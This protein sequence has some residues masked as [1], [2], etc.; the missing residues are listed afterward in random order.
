MW[1]EWVTQPANLELSSGAVH[2]W[3]AWLKQPH[4]V[5]GRLAG[6][7]SQDEQ[8]RAGRFRFAQDRMSFVVARGILRN[9]LAGYLQTDPGSIRFAYSPNGKPALSTAIE[10]IPL[11][12]NISHSHGLAIYAVTRSCEVGIDAEYIRPLDDLNAIIEVIFSPA[13][14][15]LLHDLPAAEQLRAFFTGWVRKEAYVKAIG[16]GLARSIDQ[17]DVLFFTEHPATVWQPLVGPQPLLG[18]TLIDLFPIPD[19]SAALV[20]DGDG[21]ELSQWHWAE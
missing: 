13:E 6:T 3:R 19:Y 4:S 14:R 10:K 16:E 8:L 17:I 7:L 5:A 12:F 18:R 15:K 9:I 21:L 1:S 2:V 11:R 20:I